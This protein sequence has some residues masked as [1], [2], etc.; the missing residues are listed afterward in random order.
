MRFA[1]SSG[2]E[3]QECLSSQ[4]GRRTRLSPGKARGVGLRFSL[5]TLPACS[6]QAT[7]LCSGGCQM[8]LHD[9]RQRQE[10]DQLVEDFT[11]HGLSRRE[12]MKR[13]VAIGFSASA[14]GALLAACGGSSAA[15]NVKSVEVLNVWGGP[16]QESFKA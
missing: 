2:N 1:E 6:W 10:V 12:F 16:E 3:K 5:A 15:T 13:A 14:A 7:R 8:N 11:Q 9:R 4:C